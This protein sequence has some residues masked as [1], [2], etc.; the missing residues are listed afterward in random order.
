FSINSFHAHLALHSFP[1][2]RSSD[3]LRTPI[4]VKEAVQLV[5]GHSRPL[6]S[7]MVPLE[8]SYGRILAEGL[9][10]SHDVP[11]F[12]RSAFDGYAVRAEDTTGA[13]SDYPVHFHVLGKYRCWAYSRQTA[14]KRRSI[15][16]N[17]RCSIT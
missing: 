6:G 5:T 17:D 15:P 7:E 12:N 14:K 11:P 10:A 3:L 1:T 13:T 8:E 2:R 4:P 16:Y 9:V